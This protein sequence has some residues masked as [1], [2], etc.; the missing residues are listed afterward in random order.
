MRHLLLTL[1]AIFF[2][3]AVS[4]QCIESYPYSENFDGPDF[5]KPANVSLPGQIASC[6]NRVPAAND[7]IWVPGPSIIVNSNTGPLADK[8]GNGKFMY[9]ERAGFTPPPNTA[10]LTS[11]YI[12]LSTAT[13][14]R[15]S[16]WY[17]MYGSQIGALTTQVS[18]GSG[19]SS[20]HTISGAQ[21]TTNT[22]NWVNVIVPLSTYVGD[23]I[24]VRFVGQKTNASNLSRIAIDEISIAQTPTCLVPSNFYLTNTTASTTTVG[25][26]NVATSSYEIEYGLS[27]F[28]IGS[29]TRIIA[30]SN[31]QLI[32]GLNGSTSY[33]FYLRQICAVNDTS[34]WLGPE[35]TTTLCSSPMV[36]PIYENFDS[37]NWEPY[38]SFQNQGNIAP[39]WARS[40]NGTG[41]SWHANPNS[42]NSFNT[43]PNADHTSGSGKYVAFQRVTGIST[44]FFGNLRSPEI[45][46]SG[47]SNPELSFWYH[48]YGAQI[49]KLEVEVKY[50]SGGPFTVV[51]TITGQQQTSSSDPWLNS[52]ISLSGYAD[53]IVLIRFKGYSTSQFATQAKISIDDLSIVAGS[54]CP[55]PSNLLAANIS[56]TTADVS[57]VGAPTGNYEV[58]RGPNG[59]NPNITGVGTTGIGLTQTISGLTQGTSYDIY[60][61]KL[62]FNNDTSN[63]L[64]PIQIKTLCVASTPYTQNFDGSSWIAPLNFND[65]GSVDDC[66]NRNENG[67][68]SWVVGPEQFPSF[69]TGPSSDHTTGTGK[70]VFTQPSFLGSLNSDAIL[71]T[72]LIDLTTLTVPEL[73]FWYHMFGNQIGTLTVDINDGSGWTQVFT[74]SGQVQTAKT[75][76]WKEVIVNLSSY[77]ND[78]IQIRFKA[79]RA[80]NA[81]NCEIAID[82]IDVHEQPSCPKPQ[83][84]I[85]SN[86]SFNS[87]ELAWQTGGATN[88]IIRLEAAGSTN[89]YV[90]ANTNPFTATGLLPN[91]KY[92]VWVRDSCGTADV[93]EWSEF[94]SFRTFCLPTT[95]PFTENFDGTVFVPFSLT[96]QYGAID[97]C[98]KR[99]DTTDFYWVPGPGQFSTFQTGPDVDASGTGQFMYTRTSNF[100]SDLV[101]VFSSPWVDISSLSLPEVRFKYHMYGVDIDKLVVTLN[102]YDGSTQ[103]IKTLSGQSHTSGSAAWLQEILPL[104]NLTSDTVQIVFTA[105]RLST[106]FRSEMAIDEVELSNPLACADPTS[107]VA[108]N[109]T[110]NSVDLTWTSNTLSFATN[111]EYGPSGFT[112]GGGGTIIYSVTSPYT[113]SGLSPNTAYD[114]YIQDSCSWGGLSTQIGPAS[115]TTLP[116]LAVVSS[117]VLSSSTGLNASFSGSSSTGSIS[118]YFW[119]FG[120][121]NTDSVVSPNHTY[122]A[123]GVY[124]VML[125]VSSGCGSA[126]TAYITVSICETLTPQFSFA[127][128]GLTLSVDGSVSVGT[129]LNFSWTF[130]DGN[131]GA[132]VATNHTYSADGIYDVWLFI[133]DTCGNKDS[134]MQSIA[135]CSPISAQINYTQNGTTVLFDGTGGNGAIEW[136][137]LFG[138][139]NQDTNATISHTYASTGT[140]QITLY[141]TNLCGDKDTATLILT[142]CNAPKASWKY[143]IL[144]SGGGG[145]TVQ[146][147][148]SASIGANSFSWDFGDGNTNTL[149]AIPV[150]TYSVPGLFY[151]VS[152]T[153]TNSCG[154]EDNL[155]STLASIG[156]EDF[157]TLDIK[158]FPNPADDYIV[159]SV[160]NYIDVQE[161]SIN[162]MT[163]QKM[164][165]RAEQSENTISVKTKVFANGTYFLTIKTDAGTAVYQVLIAH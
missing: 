86:A 95:A 37:P 101:T 68:Y 73:S 155:T 59:F 90:A 87:V 159:L 9:T 78:T 15:L 98:F 147:D 49:D 34:A 84:L 94:D 81:F 57:W 100:Q 61:R 118:N 140:Y 71:K 119:D 150:H 29:G 88:W 157:N 107:L 16:F 96:N 82:D 109:P 12:D 127:K 104:A 85:A 153:V 4:S 149:S 124:Q 3:F 162:S 36:A 66:F 67:N 55:K 75:D 116:C 142:L 38:S 111:I 164:A 83:N 44:N 39:C 79:T 133:T 141:T 33:D 99:T 47:V 143:S 138:D 31:P 50:V 77:A 63:W 103:T 8:S 43:G 92:K 130:G 106:G 112:P 65:I 160:P 69:Q 163:G 114:F 115:A 45:D 74:K 53:S 145:M 89:T 17:Y 41:N 125:V 108:A 146:F 54:S 128:N 93:S 58:K 72:E 129:F 137:W 135:I 30:S 22:G 19:W 48:M 1:L 5:V 21:Q 121:G 62:C 20:V 26:T 14:P 18:N 35:N 105:H 134:V 64:G 46:L 7:Y 70:Y 136:L 165:V 120:D 132:G 25:W 148:G 76:A 51:Q 110:T 117:P 52:T 97:P 28:A 156:I 144:S 113:V 2:S 131:S 102:G 13:T 10:N 80:Q 27:G 123:G 151:N 152:L 42:F 161:I 24:R 122:S 6:W 32:T 40:G 56:A 158:I 23:T 11:P 60:V 139:G 154:D 126:D 91:T